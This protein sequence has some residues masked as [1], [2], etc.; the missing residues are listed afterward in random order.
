M[1]KLFLSLLMCIISLGYAQENSVCLE[2]HSD[3]EMTG[4]NRDGIEASMFVDAKVFGSSVHAD[5]E[6]VDCHTD[7]QDLEDFPHD[8]SLKEVDCSTCHEDA[9]IEYQETAHGLKIVG[10]EE[11][12]PKCWDCHGNH[13]ILSSADPYSKTYF[14]NLPNTCCG[15]HESRNKSNRTNVKQ[16]CIKEQYWRGVHGKLVQSGD[17][18]APTCN[19]CHPA[20]SIRKQIDPQSVTHKM[21]IGILCGECHTEE[22]ELF[23]QSIH[24]EALRHGIISSASCVD[25]H[26]EHEILHPD[27]ATFYSSFE[28]CAECHNDD[29]LIQKYGI[30]IVAVSTYNDSYHGLSVKLG[31]KR[32]ATC[33]SCHGNHLILPESDPASTIHA[34]NLVNTCGKCHP[35]STPEFAHSYTHETMLIKENPVNYWVSVIYIVLIVVVIGGMFLHNAI[36]FW[37]YIRYKRLAEKEFYIVRFKPS[38]IFQH[39]TLML[40]FTVLVITGFALR[41]PEAG[42]VQL[43]QK[44]GLNE[45]LR[46]LIH[47][48]AA[49][50]MVAISLYHIYFIMFTERGRYLFK[51]ILP[52]WR[53][54]TEISQTVKYYL[55]ISREKPAYDEFDYTEKAEYWA[56][57]W[58]NIIMG[59]TGIILWFPTL[60]SSF[61]PAWVIRVAELIH[62]YEAILAT[63]AII[64]FHLFFVIVHPEQ[65]PMNLSWLTGKMSLRAAVKKH[66]RWV[67]RI[68]KGE[69]DSDLLP[70]VVKQK[71]KTLDDVEALLK[72][73]E[74]QKEVEKGHYY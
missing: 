49:V 74:V 38:E 23:A 18:S 57:V 10:L 35:A 34:E 3:P 32:A 26:G 68:L 33:S 25:C 55:G 44:A 54:L 9:A 39:A 4:T 42:W 17:D 48:V 56:L 19:T 50:V 24:A 20:H 60:I 58:G 52:N 2:C 12:A 59:I 46:G 61:A 7:L 16:P 43:L 14:Q 28:A 72:F 31:N 8:E 69:G 65:Y 40:S 36:I 67:E 66:P 30:N 64:I 29:K 22:L 73:G 37:R 63:L 21:N 51:Q 27:S 15:C 70:E 62:F 47:R 71:C 13:N 53:D 1:K 6:C 11:L 45:N 41:Y 5:L